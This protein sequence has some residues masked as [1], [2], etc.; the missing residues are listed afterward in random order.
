MK[1]QLKT[2]I[3]HED[4]TYPYANLRLSVSTQYGNPD[5]YSFAMTVTPYRITDSNEVEL[6]NSHAMNFNSLNA[7]EDANLLLKDCSTNVITEIQ[8]LL[9]NL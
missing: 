8:N 1:L 6:L 5:G 2:P 9:N 3:Q 7:L 4:S